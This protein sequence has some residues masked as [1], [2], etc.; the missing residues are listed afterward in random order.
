[1]GERAFV[2]GSAKINDAG[3]NMSQLSRQSI[4]WRKYGYDL[5]YPGFRK[6]ALKLPVDSIEAL[7]KYLLETYELSAVEYGNW[8][9]AET[10]F[11][12]ALA[13]VVSMH[14]ICLALGFRDHFGLFNTIGIG[15][16]SR[17]SGRALAHFEPGTMMINLTRYHRGEGPFSSGGPGSLAHE[18]GHALD[19]FFGSRVCGVRSLSGGNSV[20]TTNPV[21]KRAT[22]IMLMNRVL[23]VLIWENGKHQAYT[24]YYE[25]CRKESM[26]TYYYQRNE[27]FARAFEQYIAHKL[28]LRGIQNIFLTKRKYESRVY[29]N[30]QEQGQF[31]RMVIEMDN[32]MG[33]M[34]QWILERAN[35][36]K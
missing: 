28:A 23:E 13:T 7:N 3:Q 29:L 32:L 12:Y 2:K 9:N 18:Y 22:M 31:D 35:T 17:G 26:G 16:G 10:R 33:Y 6:P 34:K 4:W 36:K 8:V 25:R 15:F 27:L 20:A 1:M 5:F 14:D 19:Y 21:E 30:A 11:N 24:A